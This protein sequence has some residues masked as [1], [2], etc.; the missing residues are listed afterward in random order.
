MKPRLLSLP[1][2]RNWSMNIRVSFALA[3]SFLFSLRGQ[4]QEQIPLEQVIALALEKNYDVRLAK[5]VS[6][7]AST[8][9]SYVWGAFL[10][11]VNGTAS[12][13]WSTNKQTFE[14]D[15]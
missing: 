8:N 4:A 1:S 13:V 6:E 11:Q 5:N 15:G 3:L 10:P 2:L 9:K 7:S 14:Y 12:K